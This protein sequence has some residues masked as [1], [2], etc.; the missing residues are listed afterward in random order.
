MSQSLV[1][2]YVHLVF[3][4][5]HR[6]PWIDSKVESDLHRYMV[7]LCKIN[8]SKAIIVGGYIDH[9]HILM[10]LSKKIPLM[11]VVQKIKSNSSRWIKTQ[12]R[13]YQLFRWQN[14]YACFSVDYRALDIVKQYILNQHIHHSKQGYQDE[15]RLLMKD[16]NMEF[17]ELYC[18]D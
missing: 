7:E 1:R 14:G 6:S 16:N 10:L 3:S 12:G 4:T 2:N 13:E 17:D 11:T 15:F 5:K 8:D 18:W 9:I